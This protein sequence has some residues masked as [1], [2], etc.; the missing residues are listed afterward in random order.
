[1]GLA[2][3]AATRGV[4]KWQASGG[5]RSRH[6]NFQLWSRQRDIEQI[7]VETMRI[8]KCVLLSFGLSFIAVSLAFV[9]TP[10]N[11]KNQVP[12]AERVV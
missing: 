1:M 8:K 3:I 7:E 9:L 11:V 10:D 5:T 6:G 2:S 4:Q 12:P